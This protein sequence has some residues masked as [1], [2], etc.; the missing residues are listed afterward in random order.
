M[1]GG[2]DDEL[3]FRGRGVEKGGKFWEAE[4]DGGGAWCACAERMGKRAVFFFF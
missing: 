1:E 4:R 2:G 3:G